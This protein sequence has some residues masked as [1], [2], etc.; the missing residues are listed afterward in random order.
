[1]VT[2]GLRRVVLA[3]GACVQRGA[4]VPDMFPDP[5]NAAAV[6]T[7]TAICARCPVTGTCLLLAKSYGAEDGVWGGV[8]LTPPSQSGNGHVSGLLTTIRETEDGE[9]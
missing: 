4:V 5:A 1:V 7:A 3:D 8:L 2:S 6:A 9:H